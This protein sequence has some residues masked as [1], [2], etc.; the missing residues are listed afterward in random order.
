MF[1]SKLYSE[2]VLRGKKYNHLTYVGPV[3]PPDKNHIYKCLWKCD[4]GGEIVTNIYNVINGVRQSC[5]CFRSKRKEGNKQWK[6][7]GEITGARWYVVLCSAKERKLPVEISIQDAWKLFLKQ[8]RKCALTGDLI[9]FDTSWKEHD[10]T[11]SL[12]RINSDKGYIKGNVQWVHRDIN[13]MKRDYSQERFI[14][15]CKKVVALAILDS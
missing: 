10:G 4:C 5:N 1:K 13:F 7:F 12:D 9:R 15:M 2:E 14:E 8:N 11:A 6:G 3:L